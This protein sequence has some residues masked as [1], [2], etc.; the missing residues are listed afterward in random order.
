MPPLEQVRGEIEQQLRQE[1]LQA[2]LKE[3]RGAA[4]IEMAESAVPPAAIRQV[5]LLAD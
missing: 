3:L 2:E 4:A 1:A 5:E